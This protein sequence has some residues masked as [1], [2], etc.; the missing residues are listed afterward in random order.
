MRL[1]S[2]LYKWRKMSDLSLRE[3][4]IKIGTS[5]ATLSRIERGEAMD[6]STLACILLWLMAK[7][8]RGTV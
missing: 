2:V 5:T 8:R 3:A 6:G 7:E 1:G 4:S